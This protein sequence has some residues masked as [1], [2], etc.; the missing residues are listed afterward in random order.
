[1]SNILIVD[2]SK[3]TNNALS[4]SFKKDLY[5]VTQVFKLED[6]ITAVREQE[7]DILKAV[8]KTL[9]IV[10]PVLQSK[11]ITLQVKNEAHKQ[12]MFNGYQNEFQQVILKLIN[13]AKDAILEKYEDEPSHEK[14]IVITIAEDEEKIN[15]S[16]SDN[17]GGIP[18]KIIE[19]IFEP[20]YTTK[21]E[22]KGTGVG[23]YMSKMIIEQNMNGVLSVENGSDGAIFTIV[24]PKEKI[25]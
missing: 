4:R 6:A 2:D 7:F 10:N 19:R 21:E 9:E 15:V 18:A 11:T 3:V 13:N 8:E 23:L 1:M 12:V 16:V 14:L 5:E 22:G 25:S 17:G 20:Y 24:L